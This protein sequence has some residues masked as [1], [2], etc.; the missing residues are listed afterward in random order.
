MPFKKGEIPKG[1]KPFKK[2]QSG[3]PKGAPKKLPE[4]NQL[5][6]DVLG[7][8]KDGIEAA[9]AIL[10]ALRAKATKGD[11]RAAELLLD[12]AYGK[13]KQ[14]VDHTTKGES[15]NIISLGNGTD[16]NAATT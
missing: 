13:S 7:E 14:H 4:I 1:A 9:K 3:N 6:A 15:I 8:E 11:V 16:P 5:L 2:G 12:R 10:M